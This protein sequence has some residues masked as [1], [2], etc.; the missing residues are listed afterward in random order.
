MTLADHERW[1]IALSEEDFAR[2]CDEWRFKHFAIPQDIHGYDQWLNYFKE[3]PPSQIRSLAENGDSIFSTEAYAALK[4][5]ADILETPQRIDKIYQAGLAKPKTE[6]ESIT[7][8]AHKNDKLAVMCALRDELAGQLE[9]GAGARDTSSL[10]NTLADIMDKIS[11]IERQRGPGENTKLAK[12]MKRSRNA[13]ARRT[14]FRSIKE[15]E[16]GD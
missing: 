4:R 15:V 13:G 6:Q 9:K 3:L 12:I 8:L 14:S 16:D 7:E 11:E 2:L 1:F 10:A 5:W